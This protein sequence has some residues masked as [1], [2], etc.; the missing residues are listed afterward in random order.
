MDGTRAPFLVLMTKLVAA[1]PAPGP[2]LPRP[3][4]LGFRTRRS[5]EPNGQRTA[6][7]CPAPFRGRRRGSPYRRPRPA[8]RKPGP[9]P[10]ALG[11]AAERPAAPPGSR[12]G[13]SSGAGGARP[14]AA[15]PRR[16]EPRSG[17]GAGGA[18]RGSPPPAPRTYRGKRGTIRGAPAPAEPARGAPSLLRAPPE[19]AAR[20]RAARGSAATGPADGEGGGCRHVTCGQRGRR[21]GG[22]ERGAPR[23][24]LCPGAGRGS[25]CRGEREPR[26][27]SRRDPGAA[28]PTPDATRCA[29]RLRSDAPLGLPVPLRAARRAKSVRPREPDP[30][31]LSAVLVTM[32]GTV[33]C[34]EPKGP[35][36]RT[37][38]TTPLP[39][40]RLLSVQTMS[41]RLSPEKGRKQ[42]VR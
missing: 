5:A 34:L 35:N 21:G 11:A 2:V 38:S 25:R 13:R 19:A 14:A 28:M 36:L 24:G 40:W 15:V 41:P 8:P 27:G 6:P 22:R 42:F 23:G 26:E 30:P 17:P 20:P 9:G 29:A 10:A 18:G 39:S 1:H 12:L 33:L 37:S 7:S 3:Y 32:E 4:A 31:P 16:A